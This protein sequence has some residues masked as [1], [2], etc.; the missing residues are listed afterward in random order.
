LSVKKI[1]PEELGNIS[2]ESKPKPADKPKIAKPASAKK[3]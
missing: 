2:A 1:V 3:Q